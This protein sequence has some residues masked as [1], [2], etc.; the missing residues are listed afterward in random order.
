MVL[1]QTSAL[2]GSGTFFQWLLVSSVLSSLLH[3]PCK[4][5]GD[6]VVVT[7]R[8]SSCISSLTLT[9]TP[10]CPAQAVPSCFP[11]SHPGQ[12]P[13]FPEQ[14]H[15]PFPCLPSTQFCPR[16]EEDTEG[17]GKVRCSQQA[18]P[19]G[20]KRSYWCAISPPIPSSGDKG[21]PWAREVTG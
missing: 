16:P 7:L 14:R 5:T 20:R 1:L 4:T 18:P 6:S 11:R 3:L 15:H 10:P 17:C 9:P 19:E 12:P 2:L 8:A 13:P 21:S